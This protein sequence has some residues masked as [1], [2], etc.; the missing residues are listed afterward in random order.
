MEQAQKPT[1]K[2]NRN[3]AVLYTAL[4][5]TGLSL[6]TSSLSQKAAR[7]AEVSRDILEIIELALKSASALMWAWVVAELVIKYGPKVV[8]FIKKTI[9]K[10]KNKHKDKANVYQHE[11]T[12]E[13][14]QT[15]KATPHLKQDLAKLV[16]QE[17]ETPTQPNPKKKVNPVLLTKAQKQRD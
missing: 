5:T 8:D 2:F 3:K 10:M 14:P 7:V 13:K 15:T 4:A 9:R 16:Q 11:A 17:P 6:A 12:Q 1:N